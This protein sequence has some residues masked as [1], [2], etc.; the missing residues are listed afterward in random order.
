MLEDDL[1]HLHQ[2]SK[3][4]SDRTSRMKN[5]MQQAISHSKIEAKLN[6]KEIC[7]ATAAVESDS[8]R[9][10]KKQKSDAVARG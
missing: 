8:K 1:E 2:T 6:N 9:S 4:I 10:F 5:K 3:R 7:E